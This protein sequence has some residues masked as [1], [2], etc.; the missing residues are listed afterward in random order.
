[1]SLIVILS[2]A[3]DPSEETLPGEAWKMPMNSSLRSE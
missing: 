3:K 2:A 1:M